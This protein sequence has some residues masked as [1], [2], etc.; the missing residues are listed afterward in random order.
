MTLLTSLGID[1]WGI[2]LYLVNF[3]L[4]LFVLRKYLLVPLLAFI[5][6]R[7]ETIRHSLVMAEEAKLE[8]EKMRTA[9]DKEL[10]DRVLQM[11]AEVHEVK[12]RALQQ[13]ATM[14][15]EAEQR[16]DRMIAEAQQLIESA[17]RTM[18]KDVE[19]EIVARIERA[20]VAILGSRTDASMVRQSI[21]EAWRDSK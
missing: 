5:D 2:L 15:N 20:L 8:I 17:K 18:I 21:D 13:A 16:R 7:R 6:E 4:I 19:V 9:Y 14:I 3:G 10:H 1:P 12:Q 11:E